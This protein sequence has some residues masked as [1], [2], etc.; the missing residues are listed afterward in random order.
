LGIICTFQLSAFAATT[1]AI[2]GHVKAA[3]AGTA[4]GGV[5]VTIVETGLVATTDKSGYYIFTGVQ[6][7]SYTLKTNSAVFDASESSI[8]VQAD[9]TTT[10]DFGLYKKIISTGSS[11]IL[12]APV[13][14]ADTS[15]QYV[16]GTRTEQLTKSQPN[17][18]YQFPGL[19]FGQPGITPDPSGY[20]HVRGADQNQVGFTLDGIPI[21]EHMTGQFATNIVTVGL[22]S[23]N[24]YS[25]TADPSYGGATG[26]FINELTMNGRDIKG[27]TAELT[28]GPGHGWNY[29]G[30]NLQYGN[31]TPNGKFDYYGSTIMFNNSFP[32]NTQVAKVDSFDGLTKLN[33]Y[34]D[35]NNTVSFLYN[36]G[37]EKYLNYQEDRTAASDYAFT[38]DS[39]GPTNSAFETGKFRQDYSIQGYNI[40]SLTYKHNFT[41]SSFLSYRY[42]HLYNFVAFHNENTASVYSERSEHSTGHQLD[43][44]N[45]V[46]SKYQLRAG[47]AYTPS[48]THYRSVV[49]PISGTYLQ[50]I[51]SLPSYGDIDRASFVKPTAHTLY[52][53]NKLKALNDQVTLDAGVRYGSQHFGLV[54]FA[55]Y[56][57]TYVDP[58]LG[59]NYSPKKDLVLRASY[60]ANSQF[61]DTRLVEVLFPTDYGGAATATSPTDQ[62]KRMASRYA[63]YNKLGT[64][65]SN[66]YE[67]GVEKA[68][69][70]YKS[71]WSVNATLFERYQYD[72]IQYTRTSYNPL[73]GVRGYDNSGTGRANGVEFILN[74][75]KVN[76]S[77]WN[78]FFSYTNQVSRASSSIFDTGYLPYFYNAFSGDPNISDADFRQFNR[79]RYPTTYDQ[80][81]TVAIVANKKLNKWFETSAVLDAGSG[82]PF[83]NGLASVGEGAD[84]QHSEQGVGNSDF[85]E[86]P[87][88][89]LDKQTLQPLN[90][91]AGRSGWHYKLSINSNFILSKATSLFL[92]V[93]NVLD[94]KTVLNYSTATQQ[95]TPYY[96]APSAAYPQGRVYYGKSTIITPIFVSFGVR[97]KF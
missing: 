30:T 17:N 13:R 97:T 51:A 71:S 24:V 12:A 56:T 48:W 92:N 33:Y 35:P 61:P 83:I 52:L 46:T 88:T 87:V 14:R 58:R 73:G 41:P 25:G 18:L 76:D 72:L 70:A 37:Y 7:G 20:T 23:A 60:G 4:L 45:Q 91:V 26:G 86:V 95:G 66:N 94:S 89:L 74:K 34:A 38:P 55:S 75:R 32:G 5:K 40:S 67:L 69:N 80:R 6:P 8:A 59:V 22:K 68:F 16:I 43:Y 84:A 54:K 27:G 96:E 11:K 82:F 2:Q 28:A 31:I 79:D 81:H 10:V 19:V 65:H 1:G 90:P 53:G 39:S 77:D 42:Y 21:T 15:T 62:Q 29:T 93:D 44:T 47:Y 3:D 49:D 64:L 50:P 9:S 85:T 57:D 78:G 36:Q 63:Q